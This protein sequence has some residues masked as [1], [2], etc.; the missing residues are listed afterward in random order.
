MT[1]LERAALER[2]ATEMLRDAILAEVAARPFNKW[3][4][5]PAAVAEASAKVRAEVEAHLVTA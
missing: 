2:R 1:P 3:L 5:M 4:D